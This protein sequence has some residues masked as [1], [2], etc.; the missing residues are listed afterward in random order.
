MIFY[1][2]YSNILAC[3]PLGG[4]QWRSWL[5]HCATSRKAAGS[6]GIFHWHNFSGRTLNLGLTQPLAEMSTKNI[7][8]G[9]RRLVCRAD[10]LTNF[11]YRLSSNL[12]ASTS[13][14]PNFLEF[15]SYQ[16]LYHSTNR[17][18]PR[19]DTW[20]KRQL[21]LRKILRTYFLIISRVV[22]SCFSLCCFSGTAEKHVRIKM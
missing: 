5:R 7:S 21:K 14:L 18:Y 8:R 17:W 11:M 1:R 9:S 15:I 6:I 10:N 2:H 22:I 20:Q 3:T 4:T 16:S 19:N 12:G 13:F